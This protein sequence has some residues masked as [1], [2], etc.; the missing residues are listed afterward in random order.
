MKLLDVLTAPWAIQPEKLLEIQAI[1]AAH[2]RGDK[3]DLAGVEARLGRPLANEHKGYDVVDGVAIVHAVGVSAKRANM[4]MQISGGVST[5]LLARDLREAAADEVAHSIVLRIDSPGGTVDGTQTLAQLVR[6]IRDVKPIVALAGGTMASA[7]YWYG[8][9]AS[10]VYI[11]DDTTQVGS[12]GV[13]AT[14]VD[15]SA[16]ESQR[17]VRTTEITAGRYKRIASQY[18]PLSEEGRA[19]MQAHVDHLYS[20]FVNAVAD[21]RGV[22]PD[23]V[24]RDMADGRVFIG[25]QAIQAGLVDG[26]RSLEQL[27]DQ[28][29]TDRSSAAQRPARAALQTQASTQGATMPITRDQ[30]AADAPDLLQALL[31]EGASAERQRIQ[32]VQAQ[33]M[34]GHDALI[35]TMA[36][37]GKTTGPMAAV[38]VL[39][40]ERA[41]RANAAQQLA[42]DAPNPVAPAATPAVDPAPGAAADDPSL[43]LEERCKAKWDA[44]A[45]IRAEFG[46][47][48]AAYVAFTRAAERGSARIFNPARKE[49]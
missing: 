12:I 16:A 7:A 42:N 23:T 31:Q 6:A 14:H 21:H 35:A 46:G 18:A 47:N 10:A 27:I 4:F 19:T 5:E 25:S 36:F 28:L 49:G 8:S 45:Q 15:V 48:L 39:N 30:L 37:D 26:S 38:A 9:A 41:A 32:D 24:V 2:V 43:P 40:A 22:S 29:N 11:E 1:Y 34:P 3:I 33:A 44:S 13:V 17:G 20:V